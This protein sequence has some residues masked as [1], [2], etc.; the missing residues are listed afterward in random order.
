M[1]QRIDISYKTIIFIA[2]FILG[3]WLIFLIKDLLLILFAS[4]ILM[5][6][7]SPLVRVFVEWK[8]PKALSIGITYLIILGVMAGILAGI[9]PPLVY[10]T[11]KLAT[12]LPPILGALFNVTNIDS[13]VVSSELA[14]ISKNFIT[15]ILAVF[16]NFLTIILLLVI[17]FYLLLE[18]EDLEHRI[19]NLFIGREERVKKSIV[20]IEEKLGAWLRGQLFLSLLIGV[21]SYIGLSLLHIPYALPLAVIA[22]I[23]EVVPVIGPIISAIPPILVALT[24]SPLLSLAV[25]ALYF[26][27]QQAENHL[28]VPQV[29]KAAVGLNPLIVILAIALGSRLLGITG[30]LLAVPITVVLQII[31]SEIIE[32]RKLK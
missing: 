10:E 7:L 18:K 5:S 24:I 32:E 4:I 15:F 12:T 26:V 8:I 16:D 19:A 20:Q 29:M 25:V 27:I 2:V 30:A 31:I 28:I 17:T 13:S 21:L 23:M 9:L 1:P 22:G 11:R 3:L 14:N 6:A